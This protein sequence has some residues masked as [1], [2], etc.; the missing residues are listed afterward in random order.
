[1]PGLARKSACLEAPNS[2]NC[3]LQRALRAAALRVERSFCKRKKPWLG[4]G[5]GPLPASR[6]VLD[7]KL[8]IGN[9]K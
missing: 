5:N 6:Q 8:G 1:M 9:C 2:E 7:S 3:W 4:E